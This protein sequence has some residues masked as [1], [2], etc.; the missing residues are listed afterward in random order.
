MENRVKMIFGF[1]L[2]AMPLWVILVVYFRKE[3]G[4]LRRLGLLEN[5][6]MYYC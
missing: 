2:Y 3:L 4:K 5:S 6:K 1:S